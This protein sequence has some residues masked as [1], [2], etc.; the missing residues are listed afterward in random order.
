MFS[1]FLVV[2]LASL[3]LACGIALVFYKILGAADTGKKLRTRSV[4]VATVELPVGARIRSQDIRIV[5]VPEELAPLNCFANMEGVK[6]RVVTNL[7]MKDEPVV[8]TR[9]ASPGSAPGLAPMI[10]AGYRAVSVRVNDVIGVAGFIQPGMRVDVL[11]SGRVPNSEDSVT[12]T[13]LQ[14]VVVLSAG[15]VLQPEPKGQVINAQVVTLQVRPEEA[16]I[17]T[18]TS[19]EGRIQLV[20]RNSSD[21]T[22]AP[23]PGAHLT[24]IYSVGAN[25]VKTNVAQPVVSRHYDPPISSQ[26]KL[27]IPAVPLAPPPVPTRTVEVIRGIMRSDV[28]MPDQTPPNQRMPIHVGPNETAPDEKDKKIEIEKRKVTRRL[29]ATYAFA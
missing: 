16:E 4:V 22:V 5:A 19:G 24:A 17:L 15:Q 18:L 29:H 23:T 25:V 8:P 27:P 1:R 7:I 20:L 14:N 3:A 11:A 10:P 13:V 28:A 2:G 26:P 9:L 21:N 6:D 12:R